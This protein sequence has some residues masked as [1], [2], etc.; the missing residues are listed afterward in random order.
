MP[1]SH[2][3]AVRPDLAQRFQGLARVPPALCRVRTTPAGGKDHH[4]IATASCLVGHR[5]HSISS[6]TQTS[7]SRANSGHPR[8]HPFGTLKMRLPPVRCVSGAGAS[9]GQYEAAGVHRS[10]WWCGGL[11]GR[12][13]SAAI[14]THPGRRCIVGLKV[15]VSAVPNFLPSALEGASRTGK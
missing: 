5:R 3:R 6:T 2:R 9:R 13:A 4:V 15:A 11:A 12:G 14:K 1:V 7:A 8:E 10:G